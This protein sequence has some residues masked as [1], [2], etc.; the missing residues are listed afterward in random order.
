MVTIAADWVVPNHQL[1][2]SLGQVQ[3]GFQLPKLRLPGLLQNPPC[4]SV[5]NRFRF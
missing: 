1:P 4:S 5:V 3:L 2:V